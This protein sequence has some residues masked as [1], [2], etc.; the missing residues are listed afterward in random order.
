M[1]KTLQALTLLWT[2]TTCGHELLGGRPMA[3]RSLIVCPTSLVGNW[4][5]E[6]KKWL[7]GRLA[8]LALCEASRDDVVV[9]ISQFL[10]PSNPYKVRE[11]IARTVGPARFVGAT[12]GGAHLCC[13]RSSQVLIVSYET[14]RVHAESFRNPG[15]CDLLICDECVR[16]SA[17]RAHRGAAVVE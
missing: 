4:A 7:H 16:A 10:H 3:R 15:S 11:G 12:A 8:V 5:S 13:A 1:G 6:A 2:M 9:A 17:A 14:F